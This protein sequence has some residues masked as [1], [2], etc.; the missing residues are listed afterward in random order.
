MSDIR[1]QVTDDRG[2]I[3]K[4]QLIFPGYHGYRVN[5]DLRDADIYLKDELYKKMLSIL[6]I[7]K[8]TEGNLVSS[9]NFKVLE[10]IGKLRS[11]IQKVAADIKHHTAGYSGISAP[12]RVNAEKISSLY[13]LDMKL[14]QQI[15]SLT[16]LSNKILND[17]MTGNLNNGDVNQILSLIAQMNDTNNSREK[18]LYG[19]V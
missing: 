8:N 6:D 3:K 15:V 2:T 17:S 10:S 9:G 16:D 4:L 18:L 1:D 14:Y 13:D 19:G 7:I 11:E 12:I 5:E